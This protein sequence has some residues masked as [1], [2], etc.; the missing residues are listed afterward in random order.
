[1]FSYLL[2]GSLKQAAA[3]CFRDCMSASNCWIAGGNDSSTC[4]GVD[5][6]CQGEC[7]GGGA[8]SFGSIAYSAS[9]TYFGY[10]HGWKS[11]KKAEAE[12]MKHCKEQGAQ[13]ESIVW[14]SNSC[15]AVAA[16]GDTVAWGQNDS[17]AKAKSE[18]VANC[19]KLRGVNCQ[20]MASHCSH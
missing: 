2:V 9:D 17:E 7:R 6:R 15:G 4:N 1:M 8:E 13:C 18:A 3:D 12:A 20:L 5:I 10:S 16:S 11:Q 19:T 14:F